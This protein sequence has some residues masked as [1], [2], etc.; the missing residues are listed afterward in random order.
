[1]NNI[2]NALF[3]FVSDYHFG[4]VSKGFNCSGRAYEIYIN[5][6]G[7]RTSRIIFDTSKISFG[8][9]AHEIMH[10]VFFIM[11][12][13]DIDLCDNS[14]EAFTYLNEYLTEALHRELG[15]TIGI[16]NN[17]KNQEEE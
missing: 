5:E 8:V 10:C 17:D 2:T 14:E 6:Q 7:Y 16:F 1:M 11:D 15:S 12:F 3:H 4:E 13:V 9:I